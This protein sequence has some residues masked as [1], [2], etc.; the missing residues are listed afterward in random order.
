MLTTHFR[1]QLLAR[2]L[3]SLLAQKVDNFEI[4]VCADE[5]SEETK[6][7][8]NLLLR[9]Q[10]SFI[11]APN[12]K[13][14]SQT[15]NF[16]IQLAIGEWICFLDD[17][18]SF[19]ENYFMA[20]KS[21]LC[22]NSINLFNYIEIKE[23]R[24]EGIPK[25]IH[26]I[27]KRVQAGAIDFIDVGNC[28]PINALFVPTAMAK[29]NP[30]DVRLQSHEDWDWL[31]ALKRRGYLFTHHQNFGPNIHIDEKSS[32]NSD[33]I[34]SGSRTLDFLSIYRKWPSA[35]DELK[36]ARANQMAAFG[37]PVPPFFL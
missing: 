6:K 13:G 4:I 24:E 32:R 29:Q 37:L 2:A 36:V 16:G 7:I 21:L 11:C 30:F 10:D 23:S 25:L 27:Q 5:G 15:R 3:N 9:P 17:D 18:D 12:L 26:S 1:P 31:I 33:S 20:A 8:I 14:P 28:I 22:E 19:E 34:N 35:T